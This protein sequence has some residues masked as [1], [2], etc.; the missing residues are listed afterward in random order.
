M[1]LRKRLDGS[2]VLFPGTVMFWEKHSKKESACSPRDGRGKLY[3]SLDRDLPPLRCRS[4][5]HLFPALVPVLLWSSKGQLSHHKLCWISNI[6][7]E[8]FH[9]D[10]LPPDSKQNSSTIHL[11]W[12]CWKHHSEQGRKALFQ[13]PLPARSCSAAQLGHLCQGKRFPGAQRALTSP[14][15]SLLSSSLVSLLT[16]S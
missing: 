16:V 8:F 7:S 1:A 15:A 10:K 9:A 3:S 6:P 14:P 5:V 4:A 12:R 2:H 13:G 11:Y